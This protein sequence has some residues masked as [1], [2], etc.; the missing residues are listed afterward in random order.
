MK[1]INPKKVKRGNREQR[2]DKANRKQIASAWKD[3][4]HT[5]RTFASQ[6]SDKELVSGIH[7][8]LL[9]LNH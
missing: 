6:I 5:E 3:K 1:L 4:T 9:E 8:E 2:T 7:K